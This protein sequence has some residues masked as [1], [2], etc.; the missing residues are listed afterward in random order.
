MLCVRVGRIPAKRLLVGVEGRLEL[1][2]TE[3]RVAQVVPGPRVNGRVAALGGLA[4]GVHGPLELIGPVE[5]VAVVE[6]CLR[7]VRSLPERFEIPL[8][9]L[10][11]A[12]L[13]VQLVSLCLRAPSRL[14][15]S[16]QWPH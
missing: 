12:A 5:R 14:C 4:I 13:V 6:G 9:R 2:L 16:S 3:Q 1:L 11:V 8:V 15:R 10:V 7:R